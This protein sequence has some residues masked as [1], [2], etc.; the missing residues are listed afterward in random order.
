MNSLK[1]K[2]YEIVSVSTRR[3]DASWFFDMFIIA[4]ILLNTAAL[5]LES[6]P[7]LSARYEHEFYVLE[8]FSVVIFTF[9]YILRL[10][11]ANLHPRYAAPLTG[12][13]RYALT[14]LAVIDFLAILPFY[15]PF[16]GVDLRIV[17]ILRVLR[18]L[19]L[20]KVTR[21]VQALSMIRYVL[22]NKR[23]ELY[24]SLIFTTMILLITSSLMYFVENEAQPQNF[25]SIPETMW[26]GIATLTT[27]GYGDVY[28][29]TPLGRFLGGVIAIIGIGLF[30]LPTSILASGFAEAISSDKEKTTVCPHCG[31]EHTI[32]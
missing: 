10:W 15:L 23:E 19:R 13:L 29:I 5:V 21:Y 14:P 31:K 1:R 8:A 4:L 30:A 20:F 32:E 11:T 22:R 28:P 3:G 18:L 6:F 9:E 24:L 26:W 25:A 12:R 16:I 17:R 2:V 7:D 27:V